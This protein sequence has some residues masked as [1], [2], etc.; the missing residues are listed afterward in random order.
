YHGIEVEV[1]DV[2]VGDDEVDEQLETL[3]ERFGTLTPVERAA[4]N[5]DFVTIDLSASNE[6]EPIE[7]AQASGMSYQVGRGTMLEGLD[8]ALEGMSAGD[9]KTFPSTLVGG[10]YKDQLVD[11]TVKV[12]GVKEQELPQLD[13]EFAQ[14]ASEFDTMNELRD[15]LRDRATRSARLD[16]AAKARDAVLEQAL[17]MVEIPLPDAAVSEE[18]QARRDSITQ[19]LSYAG[20]SEADYLESEGQTEDEFAAD[21][22]KRVRSSMAAQ[23]LLDDIATA[24]ALGVNEEELTE[25]MLRR[26][27]QSGQSPQDYVQHAMEH[28][29]VPEL[30]GEI[31]RGKALADMVESATVKDKS[32]NLVELKTLKPDGTYADPAELEAQAAAAEAGADE[33]RAPQ[34]ASTEVPIAGEYVTIEGDDRA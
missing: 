2:S 20:M 7:E 8:E 4:T 33:G 12:T 27:Q 16:Q 11:V 30:V 6:G 15:D 22:E 28:N 31:R 34:D 9:E 21:L 17:T 14:T 10:E 5:T 25:H 1:D 3:R 23:F 24:E 29:H 19:Q 32:G 13:D 18:I 26:A